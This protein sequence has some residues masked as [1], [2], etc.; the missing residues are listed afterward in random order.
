MEPV[1]KRVRARVRGRSLE[2]LEDADLHSGQEVTVGI[3]VPAEHDL[4][5]IEALELSAG[6]WSDEEHPD[7]RSR[8]DVLR[9]V[10]TMRAGFDR[11][12]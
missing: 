5:A 10:R 11:S 4:T 3:E 1:I 9:F 6:A 8:E 2:L 12:L 7:L